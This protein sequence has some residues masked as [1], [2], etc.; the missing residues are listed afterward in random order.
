MARSQKSHTTAKQTSDSLKQQLDILVCQ[1]LINLST[2][3]PS[4]QDVISTS[5]PHDELPDSKPASGKT[6]SSPSRRPPNQFFCFR[7]WLLSQEWFPKESTLQPV[8]SKVAGM[9]WK[10]MTAVQKQH[11]VEQAEQVK[12][13]PGEHTLVDRRLEKNSNKLSH[14]HTAVARHDNDP[15]SKSTGTRRPAA[16]FCVDAQFTGSAST[17]VSPTLLQSPHE[18]AELYPCIDPTP[19][20]IC[21]QFNEIFEIRRISADKSLETLKIRAGSCPRL[22]QEEFGQPAEEEYELEMFM[23][24]YINFPKHDD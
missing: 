23:K 7:S 2:H 11:F 13:S 3:L 20:T 5:T 4:A 19:T 1:L 24:E 12:L 22:L 17:C 16:Q 9:V 15:A 8:V 14:A 18:Y 21:D 10:K 6:T